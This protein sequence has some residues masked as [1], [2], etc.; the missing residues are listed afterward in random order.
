[1]PIERFSLGPEPLI[2]VSSMEDLK[3]RGTEG[4]EIRVDSEA[5]PA[6]ITR[7]GET[8]HIECMSGLAIRMPYDGS[9]HVV[10]VH[11]DCR[12]RDVG[13]PIVVES[14]HGECYVR[15][16]ST[17]RIDTALGEVTI[18][19]VAGDLQMGT[20]NGNL[21]LRDIAGRSQIEVIRGHLL[22]QDMPGGLTVG[23]VKGSV[24]MRTAFHSDAEYHFGP[25]A[26]HAQFRIPADSSV[27]FV[28][29][30]HTQLRLDREIQPVREGDRWIVTLGGGSALVE[31]EAVSGS[32]VIKYDGMG[33][34]PESP[35]YDEDFMIDMADF[36]AE[37]DAR[38]SEVE[39][40]LNERLSHIRTGLSDR[41]S[42]KMR[43]RVERELDAARRHVEAAQRRAEMAAE[44]AR[45]VGGRAGA[46]GIT[47]NIA[48]EGEQREAV[49]EEERLAILK[50]LE[51]GQISVE[52]AEKLLSALEG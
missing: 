7:E 28:M 27:R 4:D 44:R 38:L 41:L 36:S 23:R 21:S 50:M 32:V 13:G 8:A 24:S 25:I 17:V 51:Q 20:V 31:L 2:V 12:I 40:N 49:T 10:R 22:G 6:E 48:R 15:H 1:M 11:G 16:V 42:E 33:Y 30:A 45:R 18:R 14:A 3:V 26:G 9:L 52:E 47:I 43:R 35:I 5:L 39:A 37:L 29:P 46:A 34:R 19:E